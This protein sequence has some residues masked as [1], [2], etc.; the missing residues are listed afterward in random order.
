M[1]KIQLTKNN[2]H[3]LLFQTSS[4][5]VNTYSWKLIKLMNIIKDNDYFKT[6]SS[7]GVSPY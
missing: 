4:S 2:L 1:V 3:G 5:K 7:P 6:E